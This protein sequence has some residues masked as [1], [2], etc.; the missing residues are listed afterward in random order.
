MESDRR[1][2]QKDTETPPLFPCEVVLPP[3]TG[4]FAS[5]CQILR[6]SY[7]LKQQGLFFHWTFL[8]PIS[9]L[10]PEREQR[11]H[12]RYAT[13]ALSRLPLVK[14]KRVIMICYFIYCLLALKGFLLEFMLFEPMA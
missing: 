14:S 6:Q 8:A 11:Y 3:A 10:A 9:G 4:G 13:Q 12:Q 7:L 1:Q 5:F 2:T